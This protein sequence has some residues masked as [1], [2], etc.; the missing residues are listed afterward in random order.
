MDSD[1]DP[2]DETNISSPDPLALSPSISS[3]LKRVSASRTRAQPLRSGTGNAGRSSTTFQLPLDNHGASPSKS[4]FLST[5]A[6]SGSSP[7][8]IKV[9]V[10]AEPREDE[11]DENLESPTRK[12][13][14]KKTSVAVPLRD[15]GVP[16]P[17]KRRGRGRKSEAG[18]IP[19][20]RNGTPAKRRQSRKN[21]G[22]ED[23]DI[24]TL[25]EDQ[26]A[27][28]RR[29]RRKATAP[30]ELDP[31]DY[32]QDLARSPDTPPLSNTEDP[33]PSPFL[34]DSP[35]EPR[36]VESMSVVKPLSQLLLETDQPESSLSS[37]GT[38]TSD[39]SMLSAIARGS[40][41]TRVRESAKTKNP[42]LLDV[43]R[44]ALRPAPGVRRRI[45]FNALPAADSR[46]PDRSSTDVDLSS[47]LAQPSS[48]EL[49][50]SHARSPAGLMKEG[51]STMQSVK[52]IE[53]LPSCL[54]LDS[55]ERAKRKKPLLMESI[56]GKDSARGDSLVSYPE[57]ENLLSTQQL[58]D[59]DIEEQD[60]THIGE[61]T[62]LESEDMTMVT[63]DSLP[64]MRA[65][66]DAEHQTIHPVLETEFAG[67]TCA[68][69][70]VPAADIEDEGSYIP[71]PDP[72]ESD[73]SDM[74]AIQKSPL[75]SYANRTP[76]APISPAASN[77][78]P[79][80]VP[81][82]VEPQ[83]TTPKLSRAVK[84]GIALQG[85]VDTNTRT[86]PKKASVLKDRVDLFSPFGEDSQ[87]GLREA[88]RLGEELAKKEESNLRDEISPLA[89]R[90]RDDQSNN[91]ALTAPLAPRQRQI[92]PHRAPPELQSEDKS[93]GEVTYPSL[94]KQI[95][96]SHL[97]SPVQSELD[98]MDWRADT[99]P[100]TI[101]APP[102]TSTD[103]QARQVHHTIG[104]GH[105][106]HSVV[107]DASV[108]SLPANP[109]PDAEE[110]TSRD[111]Q[112]DI[113]GD[114]WEEEASRSSDISSPISS[115]EPDPNIGVVP[116]VQDP[117][118]FK[119][120]RSRLPRTWRRVSATDFSYA[121]ESAEDQSSI[122]PVL[123]EP[124][125]IDVSLP[126]VPETA[127]LPVE[128]THSRLGSSMVNKQV[129]SEDNEFSLSKPDDSSFLLGR[130]T[131]SKP[132]QYEGPGEDTLISE[133]F[134]NYHPV[135]SSPP[136]V[137]IARGETE[138]QSTIPTVSAPTSGSSKVNVADKVIPQSSLLQP[139]SVRNNPRGSIPVR[140]SPL[141]QQV[142]FT[143]SPPRP[144][145]P[146]QS[147][148]IQE[149]SKLDGYFLDYSDLST[150]DE[151]SHLV[152]EA[153]NHSSIEDTPSPFS[154]RSREQ[155]SSQL[156]E[157]SIGSNELSHSDVRQL[158]NEMLKH[159]PVSNEDDDASSSQL[160][161][162]SGTS[163]TSLEDDY[164][165]DEIVAVD[166]R[167]ED[168]SRTL[169]EVSTLISESGADTSSGY[170]STS[171]E[172]DST[173]RVSYKEVQNT[174]TIPLRAAAS[175]AD[176]SL[177]SE[178]SEACNTPLEVSETD[179]STSLSK[180]NHYSRAIDMTLPAQSGLIG[181]MT[182]GVLNALA[183]TSPD[184]PGHPLL[185]KNCLLPRLEPWTRT[186][187]VQMDIIY[188]LY[189]KNEDVF[190]PGAPWNVGIF[191]GTD[192]LRFDEIEYFNW[193]YYFK[194]KPGH[195][196][197]AALFYKLLKLKDINAWE[198]LYKKPIDDALY[199]PHTGQNID[200]WTI[201][202]KLLAVIVGEFVRKDKADGYII[203]MSEDQQRWRLKGE[204]K[205]ILG[206]GYKSRTSIWGYRRVFETMP[207]Q[208]RISPEEETASRAK[209][210][211]AHTKAAV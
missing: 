208:R 155:T 73:F 55:V 145:S 43:P 57:N 34:S 130:S 153:S 7:W 210:R 106:H 162:E 142:V 48:P 131:Q 203:D 120:R 63:I 150:V 19:K 141:K 22:G 82:I 206:G 71:T 38:A 40:Q 123:S 199:E 100:G 143:S 191:E 54:R 9:T 85:V 129:R 163:R 95:S 144:S 146:L 17:A 147:R 140:G 98:E 65:A 69:S 118:I 70:P 18:S 133:L 97:I 179:P 31:D 99:P 183:L 172:L 111:I 14:I 28:R 173:S 192:F 90:G 138:K 25:N 168:I 181:R 24:F 198:A 117:S 204:K 5:G 96:P 164:S 74:V 207:Y 53:P 151:S 1:S 112:E 134:H 21:S 80:V 59:D 136:V 187:Y 184:H 79:V 176:V 201:M 37:I 135:A 178:S 149:Q 35:G 44:A 94:R 10:E 128:D 12:A 202:L 205:W 20:K 108:H 6:T 26:V 27:V 16:S 126:S 114:I 93:S 39:C 189:K 121:D 77:P 33:I 91:D 66:E 158:R 15:E 103:A 170:M 49:D 50:A 209:V 137:S 58:D 122:Y 64:S 84:A 116:I 32:E 156:L 62:M 200:D 161:P 166:G 115:Q 154:E 4:I 175:S 23:N 211:K 92:P 3:P 195:I 29:G 47:D 139:P 119:P 171:Q 177:E 194:L 152:F 88:L 169:G 188:R 72:T 2:F 86:P 127:A 42:T 83:N 132:S 30:V 180:H 182:G 159:C 185:R 67:D 148:E 11:N 167:T 102:Q 186:H 124:S 125:Q 109:T 197:I 160:T 56:D 60:F 113:G 101:N 104:D 110:G 36:D 190:E 76:L 174:F 87:R 81:A 52:E 89:G 61:Q 193:G 105:G 78:P 8:K 13:R 165:E 46:T 75:L 107:E 51:N 157:D 45:D 41:N 196:V 68:S